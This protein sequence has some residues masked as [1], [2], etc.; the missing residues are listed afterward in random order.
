LNETTSPQGTAPGTPQT[1]M[2][3]LWL[4]SVTGKHGR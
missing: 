1:T 3:L 4:V 2:L